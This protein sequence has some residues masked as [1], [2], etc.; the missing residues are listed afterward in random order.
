MKRCQCIHASAASLRP[1]SWRS[2]IA[3]ACPP[4]S[5]AVSSTEEGLHHCWLPHAM[6]YH[7]LNCTE[8]PQYPC[9]IMMRPH[10]RGEHW[11]SEEV[12][13]FLMSKQL[14]RGRCKLKVSISMLLSISSVKAQECPEIVEAGKR[15][16]LGE[17]RST[18]SIQVSLTHI[19]IIIVFSWA[20]LWCPGAHFTS[21]Y[22]IKTYSHILPSFRPSDLKQ[23]HVQKN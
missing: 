23:T 1:S 21:G 7:M 13:D 6:Y 18:G 2:G 10:Y 4:M 14:T 9:N 15:D 22:S 3:L 5:S 19:W 17:R 11:G 16:G 8:F 20:F 12:S